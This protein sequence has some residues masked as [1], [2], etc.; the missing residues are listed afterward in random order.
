M[1]RRTLFSLIAASA[2]GML[3]A[4]VHAQS[5][6]A[7]NFPSKPIKLIVPFPPGS[8]TDTLARVYGQAMSASIGQPV[9]VENKAGADGAISATEVMRAA[10]DGYT[11]LFATNSPMAAAPALKKNPPYNP[12]T[13]FTPIVDI[14]R[15]TFFVY[16]AA[17][18]PASCPQRSLLTW[19][20]SRW[21]TC[22]T[23]A[24]RR[25]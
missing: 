4:P 23:R 20:A 11:L 22:R 24:N 9:L 17:R 16:P 5:A 10:P 3:A 25:R 12:V 6:S 14:G 21:F 18:P 1:T 2:L 13:D 8:A 19:P 7:Q 15:Y